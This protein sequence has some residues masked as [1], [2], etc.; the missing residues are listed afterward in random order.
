MWLDSVITREILPDPRLGNILLRANNI[1][2]ERQPRRLPCVLYAFCANIN[3]QNIVDKNRHQ[4]TTHRQTA[5]SSL[6]VA[7]SFGLSNFK[8]RGVLSSLRSRLLCTW[9]QNIQIVPKNKKKAQK[10]RMKTWKDILPSDYWVVKDL[11][12]PPRCLRHS[13]RLSSWV[14]RGQAGCAVRPEPDASSSAEVKC[15]YTTSTGSRSAIHILFGAPEIERKKKSEKAQLSEI[16]AKK[17][18]CWWRA[19]SLHP[20]PASTWIPWC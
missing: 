3:V 8:L 17:S 11:Y 19:V 18:A 12:F 13:P 10:M 9:N 4:K 6:I 14:Q 1:R 16:T 20:L 15:C 7:S 5:S 2:S